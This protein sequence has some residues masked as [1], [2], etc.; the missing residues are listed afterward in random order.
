MVIATKSCLFNFQYSLNAPLLIYYTRTSF[1]FRSSSRYSIFLSALRLALFWSWIRK[2]CLFF[3]VTIIPEEQSQIM[4]SGDQ[5]LIALLFDYSF[6]DSMLS[7]L[8]LFT[9]R[10]P[11]S[12]SGTPLHKW[13][14]TGIH[15]FEIK[16]S[17][18]YGFT[19]NAGHSHA[20]SCDGIVFSQ[21]RSDR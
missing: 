16:A 12:G 5:W 11:V 1:Q 2:S 7:N 13:S 21:V 20:V 18:F 3:D 8:L 17:Y 6:G 4:T 9:R 19:G 10:K 15:T 14:Y